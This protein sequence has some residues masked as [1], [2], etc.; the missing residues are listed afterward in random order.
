M[1]RHQ[2]Y[3]NGA[4]PCQL[5]SRISASPRS[6]SWCS[7]VLASCWCRA[8]ASQLICP[9]GGKFSIRMQSGDEIAII[10]HH[11]CRGMIEQ[12]VRVGENS[13]KADSQLYLELV[14]ELRLAS[15]LPPNEISISVKDGIVILTGCTDSANKK[16]AAEHV[17]KRIAGVRAIVNDIQVCMSAARVGTDADIAHAAVQ[18][19]ERCINLSLDRVNIVVSNGWVTLEGDVDR[20]DQCEEAEEVVCE[21]IGVTGVTN[22]ILVKPTLSPESI[23]AQIEQAFMRSAQ[24]DAQRILVETDDSTVILRGRVRSWAERAE[25]WRLVWRTPGVTSVENLIEVIP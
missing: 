22:L 7:R 6:P 21:L 10:V 16:Y 25:V 5:I 23:K 11:R 15:S 13:M 17:A 14:N 18:V 1:P 19:L 9:G 8:A 12:L 20:Y 3:R 2:D 24:I 4:R